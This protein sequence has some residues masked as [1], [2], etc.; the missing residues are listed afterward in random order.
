MALALALVCL[1]S[2]FAFAND[3]NGGGQERNGTASVDPSTMND[4]AT[5]VGV[6]GSSGLGASTSSIG[7]I[8][9]DKTVSA[10]SVTTSDGNVVKCDNSAFVTVLSALSGTS[11]VASTS[12]TP[13]STSC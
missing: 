8:W 3:E 2:S 9:T 1:G 12:T 6:D 7:R 5:L 11:N 4:W 10:D 13:G